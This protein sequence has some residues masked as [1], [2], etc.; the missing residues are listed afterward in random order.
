LL[1][2][3]ASTAAVRASAFPGDE[4]LDERGRLAATRL[5]GLVPDACE[6]LSSPAARCRETAEAAGLRPEIDAALAECDF[7]AWSGQTLADLYE[8]EPAAVSAWMSDPDACPH[9]GETLAQLAARV[10]R[11]LDGQ[12]AREGTVLAITHAGVVKAALVHAL[13]APLSTFWRIDVSPLAISELHAHDGQWMLT[14]A[15]S[16]LVE[17]VSCFVS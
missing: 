2:R 10:A 13:G 17:G 5:G 4:P 9:G 14:R 15:N 3:H 6:V 1:V 16:A 12:A 11:W 8:R 7:G